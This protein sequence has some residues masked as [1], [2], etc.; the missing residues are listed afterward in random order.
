MYLNDSDENAKRFQV[1]SKFLNNNLIL[2]IYFS[3]PQLKEYKRNI[4][5][6]DPQD[7]GQIIQIDPIVSGVISKPGKND[8]LIIIQSYYA[9][10]YADGSFDGP[11]I[12]IMR[13]LSKEQKNLQIK[14]Y[15][16]ENW[17]VKIK[18]DGIFNEVYET[19][20]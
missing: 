6:D 14:F 4:G 7:C 13:K 17:K 9:F 3:I 2:F 18:P 15:D 5:G 20:F 19:K 10:A 11:T 8:Q 12:V 1:D 16:N